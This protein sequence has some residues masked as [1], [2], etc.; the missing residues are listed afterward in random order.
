[1]TKEE[2]QNQKVERDAIWNAYHTVVTGD[3]VCPANPN[4]LT[5]LDCALNDALTQLAQA[6]SQHNKNALRAIASHPIASQRLVKVY[7]S[8]AVFNGCYTFDVPFGSAQLEVSSEQICSLLKY[9]HSNLAA[10]IHKM[11]TQLDSEL[12]IEVGDN[13]SML[14]YEQLIHL[15]LTRLFAAAEQWE[16][17]IRDLNAKPAARLNIIHNSITKD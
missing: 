7:K 13:P 8:H 17:R 12:R 15:H 14:N 1:M 9:D 6:L 2:R 16:D 10:V 4:K 11:N 5:K 3:R